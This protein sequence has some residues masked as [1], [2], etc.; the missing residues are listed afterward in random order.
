[1]RLHLYRAP[2]GG[3]KWSGGVHLH[4][5]LRPPRPRAAVGSG[6]AGARPPANT[7]FWIGLRSCLAVVRRWTEE[8]FTWWQRFEPNDPVVAQQL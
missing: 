1:M 7:A 3:C 5:S 6:Q 2:G 4:H 8:G